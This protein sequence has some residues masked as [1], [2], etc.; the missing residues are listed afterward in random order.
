MFKVAS[1]TKFNQYYSGTVFVK[2]TCESEIHNNYQ[3][4]TGLNVDPIKFN[5]TGE[6]NPGGFYFCALNQFYKWLTYN[7]V[8]CVNYRIVE[9]PD[10]ATVYI[11]GDKFKVDKF[12]LSDKKSIWYDENLCG[13]AVRQNGNFLKSYF[14]LEE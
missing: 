14:F 11:E 6:C 9:I 8:T 12:I 7:N 13:I 10:D 5:P 2:L 1:G 3:F 4:Q